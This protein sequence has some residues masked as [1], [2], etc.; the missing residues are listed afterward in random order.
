M[1]ACVSV[2]VW[3]REFSNPKKWVESDSQRTRA[4]LKSPLGAYSLQRDKDLKQIID[5]EITLKHKNMQYLNNE[6]LNLASPETFT[7]PFDGLL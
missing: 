7:T 4:T 3:T 1:Y 5:T 6:P 2:H